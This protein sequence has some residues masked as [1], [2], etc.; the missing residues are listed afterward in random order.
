M[1]GL[2][3]YG[4]QVRHPIFR[5][6]ECQGVPDTATSVAVG[7]ARCRPSTTGCSPTNDQRVRT[8]CPVRS[9]HR[10]RDALRA[11]GQCRIPGTHETGV[12]N[13]RPAEL[14]GRGVGVGGGVTRGEVAGSGGGERFGR[15]DARPH[16][17]ALQAPGKRDQHGRA[18]F[19]EVA[20]LVEPLLE[21][22]RLILPGVVGELHDA[23]FGARF[24]APR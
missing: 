6:P 18:L 10:R 19:Q 20:V 15:D 7:P 16:L 23:H 11:C 4:A 17:V 24:R 21:Q 12:G 8:A 3:S 2:P 9:D 1:L 14:D 22:D 5:T 13:D